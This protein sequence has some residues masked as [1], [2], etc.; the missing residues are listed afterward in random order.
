MVLVGLL[1]QIGSALLAASVLAMLLTAVTI[2]QSMPTLQILLFSMAL[3]LLVGP[4]LAIYRWPGRAAAAAEADRQLRLND[5][6]SS[7][8]SVSNSNDEFVIAMHAMADARCELHSPSEVIFRR[9]GVRSWGAIA[10]AM[11]IA[12][13]LAVIPF[14]PARSQ[15]VDANSAVLSA[16]SNDAIASTHSN[17]RTQFISPNNDASSEGASGI[18]TLNQTTDHS[19]T[20]QSSNPPDRTMAVGSNAGSGGGTSTTTVKSESNSQ[21]GASADRT[22]SASASTGSGGNAASSG[23]DKNDRAHGTER[24]NAK[25]TDQIPAWNGGSSATALPSGLGSDVNSDHVPPQHRDLVRDFFNG[26]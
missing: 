2:W 14:G 23:G 1:E 17:P 6:L 4:V 5:L 3:G 16:S 24:G 7:A 21:P 20:D 12:T 11:C 18:S 26:K 10:L 25:T 22:P 9:F 19:T 8:I 15:A 13:T